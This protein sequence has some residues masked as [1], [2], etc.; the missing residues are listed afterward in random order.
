[1]YEYHE[2]ADSSL[3][4]RVNI[5]SVHATA[6]NSLYGSPDHGSEQLLLQSSH[7]KMITR[8]NDRFRRRRL[9]I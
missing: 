5:R 8:Q 6:E 4:L 7:T 3:G 1:M 2:R 9:R